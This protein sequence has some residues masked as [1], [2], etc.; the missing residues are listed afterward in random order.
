MGVTRDGGDNRAAEE[1]QHPNQKDDERQRALDQAERDAL[2]ATAPSKRSRASERGREGFS[3][4]AEQG[5]PAQS[6]MVG[7]FVR[8]GW[9]EPSPGADVGGVSPVLAPM[10]AG[11]SP[12]PGA[13]VGGVNP[14]PVPMQAGRAQSNNAYADRAS[15]QACVLW[16]ANMHDVKQVERVGGRG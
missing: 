16:D 4:G 7:C 6:Q 11:M 1:Q 13:D 2:H 9:G 5:A 3:R 10:V 15:A 12:S 14:I 8:Y